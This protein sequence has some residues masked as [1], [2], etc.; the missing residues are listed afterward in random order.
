VAIVEGA[1]QS[2]ATAMPTVVGYLAGLQRVAEGY[3]KM[4]PRY[5]ST[6]R[7]MPVRDQE[8]LTS[9]IRI[10]QEG[11]LPTEKPCTRPKPQPFTDSNRENPPYNF[12]NYPGFDPTGLYIG[13]YTTL[14][15]KHDLTGQTKKLSEN[16]MDDNW[17]G[18]LY[19]KAAVD[20]GKYKENEVAPPSQS[21]P[22]V[23][24]SD[25]VHDPGNSSKRNIFA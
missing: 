18:V 11:G 22:F 15:Q 9:H 17:G 24:K 10:N 3:V 1:T 5:Y 19:T 12:G 21:G 25:N 14:D 6:A 23:E 16:P 2:N 20:S 8:G 7:M 4:M 13:K